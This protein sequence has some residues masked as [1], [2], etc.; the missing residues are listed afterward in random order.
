M[1]GQHDLGNPSPVTAVTYPSGVRLTI[2]SETTV[3]AAYADDAHGGTVPLVETTGMLDKRLSPDFKVSHFLRQVPAEFNYARISVNLVKVLQAMQDLAQGPITIV[4][5]YR[6]V[7]LNERIRGAQKS[8]HVSGLAVDLKIS[9][10]TPLESAEIAL[11]ISPQPLGLGLG[12]GTIHLDLRASPA[13][14][15]YVGSPFT[16][17]QF[18]A[19]VRERTAPRGS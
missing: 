19:W 17:P 10:M 15:V 3:G 2:V 14:W 1:S 16:A 11:R 4:S 12:A 7:S 13:T 8:P 9:G 5:G 6:P 18:E